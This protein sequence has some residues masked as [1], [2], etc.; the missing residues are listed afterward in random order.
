MNAPMNTRW[1]ARL[2]V[3]AL[4][5]FAAALAARAANSLL[6]DNYD[7]S[8][9]TFQ[10]DNDLFNGTDHDYTNGA[11]L[12]WIS[13]TAADDDKDFNQLQQWLE[14]LSGDD[15][16]P[17]LLGKLTGFSGVHD[18]KYKYG[19]SLTQLM[20][21]PTDRTAPAS[22]PGQRPYAGWL[23]LGFSVHVENKDA[24][25]IVELSIGTVGSNSLAHQTQD[26]V[27]ELRGFPKFQGWDSQVRNEATLNLFFTKRRKF[28]AT[29]AS[30]NWAVD[31]F[32]EWGYSLGNFRVDAMTGGLVRAGWNLP[33]DFSDPRL[34]TTSYTDQINRPSYNNSFLHSLSLYA[35]SGGRGTAVG[36]DSTLDGSLFWRENIGVS[37]EW[38]VGEYYVGAGLRLW[39]VELSYVDTYRTR[40]FHQQLVGQKYGSVTLRLHL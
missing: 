26:L 35:I 29:S 7:P 13:S 11:R 5:G 2:P 24:L 40:E 21:T 38:L 28:R 37:S 3:L 17:D 25:N 18:L 27:H 33:W 12:T 32:W 19:V 1:R 15:K 23:G 20:Y 31:G 30:R 34:S 14:K 9:I 36:H 16:S 6:P 8:F 4:V 10:L 22:P 39:R